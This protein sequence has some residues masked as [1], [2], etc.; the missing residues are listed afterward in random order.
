MIGARRMDAPGVPAATSKIHFQRSVANITV[1]S[2]VQ[3]IATG[4]RIGSGNIEFW[5]NNY[6]PG[7]SAN[8]PG[9]SSRD[10]DFGD[11][12]SQPVDG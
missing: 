6:E 12:P 8:V 7:N 2:D 5:P 11:S 1:Y 9:A 10:Y 4:E 3:G